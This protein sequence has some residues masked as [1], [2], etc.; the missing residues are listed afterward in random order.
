MANFLN[1]CTEPV[2][3]LFALKLKHSSAVEAETSNGCHFIEG[4]LECLD[5][6]DLLSDANK[7]CG[8]DLELGKP[9]LI[10]DFDFAFAI[11]CA[12]QALVKETD[13]DIS[14]RRELVKE[15]VDDVLSPAQ[16]ATLP[17]S[18]YASMAKEYTLLP[19]RP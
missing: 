1:A 8:C 7:I 16:L 13:G 10:K 18:L 15:C 11:V 4:Y 19:L 2:I 14:L 3:D 17:S 12:V 9:D 6:I 5:I